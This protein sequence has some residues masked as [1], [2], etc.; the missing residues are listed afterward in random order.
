MTDE[1]K[2]ENDIVETP[3]GVE[4]VANAPTKGAGK[5]DPMGKVDGE[6]E[7]GGAAV[8]S[9]DAKSSPTDVAAKK[10]KKDT[11]APTKGAAAPE[12]MQKLAADKHMKAEGNEAED[13][14][15]IVKEAE[16]PKTKSGMIQ[17]MYDEMSKMKKADIAA[18]YNKMMSAMKNHDEDSHDK[19]EE[20]EDKKVN[21]EAVENRVKSID[22]SDDVNA[23]VSGDD[24]LSEEFKTKA[25]TIFEAAV[26]SKVKSEIVR[27]EGEYESEMTEAK[28]QVKEDLTVKVDNYLNYVVEQWMTDNELAIEKGIKGE[29]AEDFIGGLKQLFEDH[30][31]DVP[32][33]KY[34]VLEA[35]EKELEDM[36]SKVNEMTEKSIEDKKLIEGYTKD[37]IFEEA[38][39][40]MAD[41]EKEKMKSLVED[42]AFEGADAYKKKLSTI[43]ESYF[44]QAKAPESTENVDTVNQDSNDGNIVADL[45]DSMARYTAAISRGKSRDIYGN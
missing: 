13:D 32:D 43:K 17:A 16:M 21:K 2:N 14:K 19:E 15:E 23:L 1:I 28:E 38:V 5:A 25:A 40:G 4:E 10:V 42:V 30:Y 11:S 6:K 35:K 22:V 39:E 33:E 36:K 18:S 20:A 44:G 37:E 9:P 26:K 45:S 7:D 29:I 3:Q 24:S 12:P 31:I 8:V 34:D 41:T 27:L